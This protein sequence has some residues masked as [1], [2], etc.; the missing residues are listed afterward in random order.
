MGSSQQQPTFGLYQNQ[1]SVEW[2]QVRGRNSERIVG[3][4]GGRL[5][6]RLEWKIVG[7]G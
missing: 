3:R 7:R 4:L 2:V 6:D 5:G 1:L